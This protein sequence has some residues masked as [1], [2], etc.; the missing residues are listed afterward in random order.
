MRRDSAAVGYPVRPPI[1]HSLHR[2]SCRL[3][4]RGTR[5]LSATAFFA[6]ALR[7][8]ACWAC[9][10]WHVAAAA[11]RCVLFST[12]AVVKRVCRSPAAVMAF[13]CQCWSPYIV[14]CVCCATCRSCITSVL[15]TGCDTM[16]KQLM[17]SPSG[18][19]QVT[20]GSGVPADAAAPGLLQLCNAGLVGL[21]SA[22]QH[23]VCSLHVADLQSL[24][25]QQS[26]GGVSRNET[27]DAAACLSGNDVGC[28]CRS[29][30]HFECSSYINQQHCPMEGNDLGLG[31]K[32]AGALA[33]LEK[34]VFASSGAARAGHTANRVPQMVTICPLLRQAPKRRDQT[35]EQRFASTLPRSACHNLKP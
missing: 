22:Y 34:S 7:A 33:S 15:E 4:H 24:S 17:P 25:L 3:Q 10:V 14:L 27:A 28:G 30:R 16:Q 21:V 13:A 32:H 31:R 29:C 11:P 26:S 5:L 20:Q 12:P 6:S 8:G 2:I 1:N 23:P 9:W 19:C 35:Q 18:L